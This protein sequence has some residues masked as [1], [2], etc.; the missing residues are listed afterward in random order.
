MTQ[1]SAGRKTKDG[2]T[3]KDGL[4]SRLAKVR[5]AHVQLESMAKE[6]P[7]MEKRVASETED[8]IGN[9]HVQVQYQKQ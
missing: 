7:L 6:T 2:P 9:F 4:T 5:A 1:I 8:L 3:S